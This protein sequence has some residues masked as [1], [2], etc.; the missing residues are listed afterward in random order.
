MEIT[1]G[2]LSAAV[3]GGT[4]LSVSSLRHAGREL[5]VAPGALPA[6][7]T[8]HGRRAGITL[9]HPWANRLGA[10]GFEVAGRQLEIAPDDS[11]VARD[12]NGLPI[13]GLAHPSG[14][15]LERLTGASARARADWPELAA[16]PF[17]HTVE[18]RLELVPA[19]RLT[20][21]TM[22]A[23]AGQAALPVSFGWHPYFA[24][25]EPVLRL[26]ER[27]RL[28]LDARGLPT[29]AAA[30]VA[31]Q[32]LSPPLPPLDDGFGAIED[33]ATWS[34]QTDGRRI[35]VR[36]D[37]GYPCAQVFAPPDADVVSLE[38]MTAPVD[39]LRTGDGLPLARPGH[40]YTA[41]FTITVE[42][43]R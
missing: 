37:F 35:A 3:E 23:P 8:V 6:P 18:V 5:L 13:H 16:F 32:T 28:A 27:R 7:Y 2:E 39:A 19:G 20:V 25:T 21:A 14:W 43:P 42:E 1:C 31:A 15:R 9:L 41:R 30:N 38:P 40:A 4:F 12:G 24:A 29:G 36:H 17:A 22:L 11:L 33:G 34:V 26:P 10:S